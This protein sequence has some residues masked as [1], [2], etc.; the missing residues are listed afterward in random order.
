MEAGL[1]WQKRRGASLV[2]MVL[3]VHGCMIDAAREISSLRRRPRVYRDWVH[4]RCLG[5]ALDGSLGMNDLGVPPTSH[6]L[7]D[8]PRLPSLGEHHE[9]TVGHLCGLA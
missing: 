1:P 5:S 2:H 3:L 8:A 9:C 7:V 6:R 4:D